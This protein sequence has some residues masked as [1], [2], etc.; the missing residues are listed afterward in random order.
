[1][2]MFLVGVFPVYE[3]VEGG[4]ESVEAR[5]KHRSHVLVMGSKRR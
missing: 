2:C 3:Y 4:V 5:E 1:M